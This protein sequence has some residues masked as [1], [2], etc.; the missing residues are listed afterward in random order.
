MPCDPTSTQHSVPVVRY[1]AMH[2]GEWHSALTA[3]LV[4]LAQECCD[5][6]RMFQ[7]QPEGD[8]TA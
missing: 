5:F 2:K 7:A 1:V 3:S 6:S 8:A 4:L